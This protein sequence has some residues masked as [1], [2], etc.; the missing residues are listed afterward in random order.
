MSNEEA[1]ITLGKLIEKERESRR[2]DG[3][4]VL[5]AAESSEPLARRQAALEAYLAGNYA[6]AERL[7]R[8]LADDNFDLPDTHCHL[9]R[10]LLIQ[11]RLA[12][13]TLRPLMAM[14]RPL[15]QGHDLVSGHSAVQR[16]APDN[17]AN[18]PAGSVFSNLPDL[19]RFTIA[20]MNDGKL[21]GKQVLSP[22]VVTALT[23]PH[24]KA[25]GWETPYGYGLNVQQTGGVRVWMHGGARAGYGS[26]I[27]L[28]PGS[29]AA[30][31]VLCNRSGE[32]LEK[33][34]LKIMEML[35][36]PQ[37]ERETYEHRI[38]PRGVSF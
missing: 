13:S 24:A 28:L 20:M 15:S 16:P 6:E 31:I 1:K 37:L 38:M 29:Q 10:L 5:D 33:T 23:S 30:V 8:S 7:L 34:H 4:A 25:P 14:T 21:E 17:A 11:N 26:F 36:A 27:A 22:K 18:W 2:S 19:S 35:G 9:A 3:V 12:S 32:S